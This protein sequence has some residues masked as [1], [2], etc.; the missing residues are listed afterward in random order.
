M[1]Q[2][3]HPLAG[4][5]QK[6]IPTI[7]LL[8]ILYWY[9]K[10]MLF[11]PLEKTLAQRDA[12]TAGARRTAEESLAAAE[13]KTAE[14]EA[15]IR[16]ARSELYREQ[17][18]LRKKWLD[19]QT[20]QVEQA[21]ERNAATVRAAR[22]QLEIEAAQARQSLLNTSGTLADEIASAVLARRAG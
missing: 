11:G 2:I 4:I 12:L 16:E 21:H 5:L 8:L 10:A 1:E 19:D 7:V 20:E 9:L 3:L 18:E 15:K 17:E 14:Y 6:A 22:E 13:R